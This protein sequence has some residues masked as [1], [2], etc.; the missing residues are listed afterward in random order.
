MAVR[1]TAIIVAAGTSERMQREGSE[2]MDKVMAEIAG[3]PVIA[4]TLQAFEDSPSVSNIVLVLGGKNL[5]RG[6]EI[7]EQYRLTKVGSLCEG[8]ATRQDSVRNGIAVAGA[9]DILVVHDGARPCITV[10]DI[11]RGIAM[12]RDGELIG[13]IAGSAVTDT[14]KRIHR[15]DEN[16]KSVIHLKETI[17]RTTL[18]AAAT[19]QIF[20]AWALEKAY[21]GRDDLAAD[22]AQL[23]EG[24]GLPVQGYETAYNPKITTPTDLPHAKLELLRRQGAV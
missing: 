20:R 13:A 19:P 17:D 1:T 21:S 12:V 8:G 15:V 24:L 6:K 16:S 22:D 23:V 2:R 10:P 4:W 3:R 7:V 5:V 18:F 9:N 14:I 11:E